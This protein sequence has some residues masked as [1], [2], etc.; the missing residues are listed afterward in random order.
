MKPLHLAIPQVWPLN[1]GSTLLIFL[2]LLVGHSWEELFPCIQWMKYF[3]DVT[4]EKGVIAL[5]SFEHVS[6]EDAHNIQ[7]HAVELAL[8]VSD[9]LPFIGA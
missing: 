5:R 2:Q 7:T 3:A 6:R 4:L 1:A 9:A 8:L